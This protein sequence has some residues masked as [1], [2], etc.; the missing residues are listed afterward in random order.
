MED[1]ER[2]AFCGAP[3]SP[4]E[5]E[6]SAVSVATPSK[7]PEWRKEVA[8]RLESYRA[9]RHRLLPDHPQNPL[10]FAEEDESDEIEAL[11][12]RRARPALRARQP[13]RVEIEIIQPEFDFSAASESDAHPATSAVLVAPLSDRCLAAAL[14][15]FFLALTFAGF[16]GMFRSLGGR[17]ELA[18]TDLL[19]SAAAFFL[20]YALY[21]AL[22][23]AMAGTT[24]G[25]QI[26][27]LYVVRMDG[28]LPTTRQLLWRSFGYVTSG[29]TIAL[30]FF[31]AL[32]DDERLT[33]HD[34]ISQT[35]VTATA[36]LGDLEAFQDTHSMTHR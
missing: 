33:W 23:T 20:L 3:L 8:R 19:V 1:A 21:F 34:R 25:M 11:P 32:W 30:G 5:N 28:T 22:F 4:A 24:P 12:P 31:W 2:C 15:G 9:R 13:E 35:Y 6:K 10:P 26:R 17:V 7:E 27:G 36:P 29:A 16:L 14:D 18:R